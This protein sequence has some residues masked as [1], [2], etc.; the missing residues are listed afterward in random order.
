MTP[1]CIFSESLGSNYNN[2]GRTRLYRREQMEKK[3]RNEWREMK[4]E[5]EKERAAGKSTEV[6]SDEINRVHDKK[7]CDS[8]VEIRA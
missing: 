8:T 3:W 7:D 5:K 4:K 1:S 2:L 6:F